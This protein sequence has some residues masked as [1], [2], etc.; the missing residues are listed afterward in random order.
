MKAVVAAFNQEKTLLFSMILQLQTSR[1]FVSS[2]S[3]YKPP[4]TLKLPS[5]LLY[6]QV[7]EP[8]AFSVL[9]LSTVSTRPARRPPFLLGLAPD[10]SNKFWVTSLELHLQSQDNLDEV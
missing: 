2:S 6:P 9:Y 3:C 1:M 7:M 10:P 8:S 5:S 4:C